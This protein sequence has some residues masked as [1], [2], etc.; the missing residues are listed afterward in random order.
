[1]LHLSPERLAAL[2]DDEPTVAEMRHLAGCAF[3]ARERNAYGALLVLARREGA[4]R[5][6]PAIEWTS[7]AERLRAEGMITTPAAA[8]VLS[9]EHTGDVRSRPRRWPLVARW[10]MRAA[11]AVLL[12]AGGVAYGRYS[13]QVAGPATFAGGSADADRGREDAT[14]VSYRSPAEAMEVFLRAQRELR[15]AAAYLAEREVGEFDA[16]GADAYRARLAALDGSAGVY[17]AALYDAP[18]DPV[19]NQLYLTTLG[20]R[21]ATVRQ[22]SSALPQG[23]MLTPF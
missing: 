18:A 2:A 16:H 19:I 5:S 9:S 17:R 7:L 1:M 4:R 22:I 11:A 6:S 15:E 23:T 12:A 10:S 21:D 20:A 8:P 14:L 13:V 3:C